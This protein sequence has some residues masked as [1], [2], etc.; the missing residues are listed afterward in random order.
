MYCPSCGIEMTQELNYCNRC[1]AN[2]SQPAN[3]IPQS[4]ARPVRL[5]GPTIALCIMVVLSL[6]AIFGGVENLAMKGVTPIALAFIAITSLLMVFGV[7]A[8]VI[9]VWLRLLTASSSNHAE[10]PAQLKRAQQNAQLPAPQTGPMNVPVASV[11]DHTT[12]TFEPAY[13]ERFERGK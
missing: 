1:G 3:L 11:T 12:R 10:H 5:T 7:S 9:Q 4:P 2:L 6:V 8:L 13:K